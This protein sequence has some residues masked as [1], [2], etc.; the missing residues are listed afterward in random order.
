MNSRVSS[1]VKFESK[2][3]FV[4]QFIVSRESDGVS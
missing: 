1:D 4:N 2:N 3:Y